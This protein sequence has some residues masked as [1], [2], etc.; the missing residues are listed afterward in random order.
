MHAEI[1]AIVAAA[2]LSSKEKSAL[3][4]YFDRVGVTSADDLSYINIEDL[5][6]SPDGPH[7]RLVPARRLLG[8]GDI[9]VL[10]RDLL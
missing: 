2:K 1:E 5:T 9:S 4:D 10:R 3:R 8:T 7:I 6:V